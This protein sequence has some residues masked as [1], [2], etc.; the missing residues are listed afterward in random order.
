MT[1]HFWRAKVGRGGI[2]P[3]FSGQGGILPQISGR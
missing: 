1:T 2:W 3:L